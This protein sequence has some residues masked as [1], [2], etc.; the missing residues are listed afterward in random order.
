[1]INNQSTGYW[2]ARQIEFWNERAKG[3]K[4]TGS[5]PFRELEY[6]F[7]LAWAA[8]QK[9][10]DAGC[11]QGEVMDWIAS[12]YRGIEVVGIDISPEMVKIARERHSE[13]QTM[14]L[15]ELTFETDAFD[16]VIAV[17]VVKNILDDASQEAA[18]RELARVSKKRIIFIDSIAESG[19]TAPSFNLYLS[20]EKIKETFLAAGFC[21]TWEEYFRSRWLRWPIIGSSRSPQNGSDE[22]FFV[23]DKDN[24]GPGSSFLWRCKQFKL[25]VSSTMRLPFRLARRLLCQ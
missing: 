5:V 14:D 18:M 2:R 19:V 15:T 13:V 1:M 17:R 8:G 20:R 22:G 16:T 7:I 21:L 23:F 24:P 4:G 9:V 6:N 25:A 10:L 12:Q 3:G 11:G